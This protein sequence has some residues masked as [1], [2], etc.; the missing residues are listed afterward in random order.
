MSIL[1]F[2]RKTHVSYLILGAIFGTLFLLFGAMS[3]KAQWTIT[4]ISAFATKENEY[5][6]FEAFKGQS[7]AFEHLDLP[8]KEPGR[9]NFLIVGM[10]GFGKEYGELLTDTIILASIEKK[11]NRLALI[12]IPRDL[13]ITIPYD[14]KV[15]IN[16]LYSIGYSRGGERLAF[17]VIKTVVSQISG[18]YIDGMIRI[19]FDGFEKLI[20]TIGGID[21]YLDKPFDELSQWEG[22]G[23]FHLP[24]GWNHLN[25]QR[26]LF[27]V[28]SRFSTSDF[29]RARRQQMLIKVLKD[30]FT[31]LGVLSNPITLY[32]ILD[33]IG[34]HIKTDIR[35]GTGEGLSLLRA[36]DDTDII[37]FVL[38]TQNYLSQGQGANGIYILLPKGG[39][40]DTIH[41]AIQNIFTAKPLNPLPY[42]PKQSL[43]KNATSTE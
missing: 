42:V 17:N 4:K 31:S 33:I 36:V 39:T 20:D 41:S 14:G 18:V 22:I 19:D 1:P 35:M 15:K 40:F 34:D 26:A 3:L 8:K 12:S 29:D 9:D 5:Q 11:L 30:K 16:E 13:F 28:R 24:R 6:L 21:I 23:G 43:A 27:F 10:R 25:G 38:S 32:N 7:Q 37:H 2:I